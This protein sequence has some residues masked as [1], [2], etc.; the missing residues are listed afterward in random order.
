MVG[1]FRI[2]LACVQI[3][4]K[5]DL[6]ALELFSFCFILPRRKGTELVATAVSPLCP[7]IPL[8][9]RPSHFCFLYSSLNLHSPPMYQPE[10]ILGDKLVGNKETTSVHL[11]LFYTASVMKMLYLYLYIKYYICMYYIN[12]FK[13]HLLKTVGFEGPK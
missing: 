4:F 12:I 1:A 13:R 3:N 9:W 6:R 8:A 5:L 7:P 10:L 2:S 11:D